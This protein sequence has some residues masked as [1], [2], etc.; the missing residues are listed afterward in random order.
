MTL[1]IA[2]AGKGGSG[3]TSTAS[4]II[5]YLMHRGMTPVLA[6]D[7]DGNANLGE[8][9]GLG[10]EDTI[11]S[12]IAD[13][14]EDKIS[15]PSGLTKGAYLELKLNQTIV[16]SRGLDLIS[17]GRGEGT[18]CYCYPNTVLKK[19]IDE[20][21][22]NYAAMVMDNE[23]G[24]EHLS[25][26]TTEDIDELLIVSDHSVKGARTVGRILELL[27]D[28][29]L[30]VRRHSVIINRVP[31]GE[32]DERIQ[33]ELAQFGVQPLATIPLDE[34]IARSDLE[35][36]SLLELPDDSVSV[37]A[38]AEMMDIIVERNKKVTQRG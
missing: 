20:L 6:V 3:K 24:M 33:Q 18:G 34:Q 29:K 2:V 11:G 14:N 15:I 8:S 27:G 32:M 21:K 35:R 26:R 10:L 28:L 1:S 19:F 30:D 25:R 13:F 22:G 5:R 36:K 17:M 4:L 7:A 23:A 31:G 38:V 16:E 9:L 12:V 37:A